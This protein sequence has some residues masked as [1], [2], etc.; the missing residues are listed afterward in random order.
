MTAAIFALSPGHL[1][2]ALDHRG[3]DQQL[4]GGHVQRIGAGALRAEAFLERGELVGDQPLHG[5][6]RILV[7][8][9]GE[10][11]A[12]E[13]GCAGRRAI[14]ARVQQRR[15]PGGAQVSRSPAAV[16]IWAICSRVLPSGIK[17]LTTAGPAGTV[18]AAFD[19]VS[20]RTS[21]RTAATTTTRARTAANRPSN[22][23]PARP[24]A[25]PS[26]A[27]AGGGGAGPAPV[28]GLA[29]AAAWGAATSGC[30]GC[31]S[32]SGGCDSGEAGLAAAPANRVAATGGGVAAG[33][34]SASRAPGAASTGWGYGPAT[35]AAC[36][37][38]GRF[39]SFCS[40]PPGSGGPAAGGWTGG[41]SVARPVPRSSRAARVRA[42]SW[43]SRSRSDG[44][45][46]FPCRD[47]SPRVKTGTLTRSRRQPALRA[48][49][50]R[51]ESPHSCRHLR[52]CAGP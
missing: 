41:S 40:G 15:A 37:P 50:P 11:E 19:F 27:G 45:R 25:R 8:G 1:R 21:S 5:R 33:S 26:A 4:V 22:E 6:P 31:S 28:S 32:V 52:G 9:G 49:G 29:R 42:R 44:V 24:R 34:T 36:P 51:R 17:I 7:I 14:L 35:S 16:A 3:D 30:R 10:E 18:C 13:V 2:L 23:R 47:R 38:A 20:E 39:R 12:F 46:S 43:R 48:G